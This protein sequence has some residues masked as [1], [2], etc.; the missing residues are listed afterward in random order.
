MLKDELVS[1]LASRDYT[2]DSL[3]SIL[4]KESGVIYFLLWNLSGQLVGFQQYIPN[5]PKSGNHPK[6]CRYYTYTTKVDSKS[7]PAIWGLH[8]YSLSTKRIFIVEGVFDAVKL[9]NIGEC[10]IALLGNAG[11]KSVKQWL[12]LIRAEKISILDSDQSS[13]A[14]KRLS[15]RWYVTPSPYKDLGEMPQNKVDAFIKEI[16]VKKLE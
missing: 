12:S 2:P 8:T 5:A 9:H 3:G 15:N 4:S 7:I 10:A 1:H 14:L 11:S 13:N 6:D 16:G